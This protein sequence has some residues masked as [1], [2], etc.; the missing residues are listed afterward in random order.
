MT[1]KMHNPRF[2]GYTD[3]SAPAIWCMPIEDSDELRRILAY[4]R[5]Q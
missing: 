3:C 2:Q 1:R 5:L 4:N